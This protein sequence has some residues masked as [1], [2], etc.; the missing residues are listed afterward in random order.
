MGN[1]SF[2]FMFPGQGS[3]YV[4]MMEDLCNKYDKAKLY[5]RNVEDLM[6]YPLGYLM[7]NGPDEDLTKT[8]YTQPAIFLHSSILVEILRENGIVPVATMG[9]SLGEVTALYAA[10]VLSFNDAL[11]VVLKRAELMAEVN[12]E[13][14][15]SAVIGLD[16]EK[17]KE[18]IK[19]FHGKV[20]IANI[21]SPSQVVISGY[22]QELVKAEEELRDS[23]AKR[24]IRLKVSNA[25]HSPL[26]VPAQKEFA[27]FLENVKFEIPRVPV[28]P[29]LEPGLETNPQYLKQLLVRQLTG[30]V[31]WVGCM[32]IASQIKNAFFVEI[33]PKRVLG[34]LL[35]E[36]VGEV[37]YSSIDT[38]SELLEFIEQAKS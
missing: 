2:V 34:R 21:N 13:G 25:F 19:D 9:H 16:I 15:M 8:F 5:L 38:A 27:K 7:F 31:N 35:K 4:G 17:V 28:I 23:G 6:G 12:S 22:V 14:G 18:I 1:K 36:T 32:K 11:K 10:G 24:V 30:T 33:G 20:V 29:N 3:Q 26:M 37:P